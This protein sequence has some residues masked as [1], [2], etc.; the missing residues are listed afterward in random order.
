MHVHGFLYHQIT[1]SYVEGIFSK[2]KNMSPVLHHPSLKLEMAAASLVAEQ[3][4]KCPQKL[5][6][7]Y[8]L[9]L[10]KSL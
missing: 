10:V 8:K 9:N 2:K 5:D 6:H 1:S 4:D 7:T 3:A